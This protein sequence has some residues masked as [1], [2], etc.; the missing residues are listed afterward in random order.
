MREQWE[1]YLGRERERKSIVNTLV[2]WQIKH[3]SGCIYKSVSKNLEK[4]HTHT[5]R[6]AGLLADRPTDR[7]TNKFKTDTPNQ[8][9][10]IL[11]L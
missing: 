10:R 2:Q 1:R 5:P 3:K 8:I 7:Q 9:D 6:Q 11:S 4:T